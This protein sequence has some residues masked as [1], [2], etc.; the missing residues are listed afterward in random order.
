MLLA[1]ENAFKIPSAVSFGEA[2]EIYYGTGV[3]EVQDEP[4]PV[5]VEAGSNDETE[6][7]QRDDRADRDGQETRWS[8][9]CRLFSFNW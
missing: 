2:P 4:E 1:K 7:W 6:Y 5:E 8:F 3:P 9:L